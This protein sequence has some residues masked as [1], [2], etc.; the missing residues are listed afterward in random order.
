MFVVVDS[1]RER[2]VTYLVV[3]FPVT[4]ELFTNE[5][6]S[7]CFDHSIV[8]ITEFFGISCLWVKNFEYEVW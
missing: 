1:F 6:K 4:C 2:L 7:K 5:V 3:F 8:C